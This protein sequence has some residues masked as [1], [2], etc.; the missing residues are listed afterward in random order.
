MKKHYLIGALIAATGIFAATAS[1][2]ERSFKAPEANSEPYSVPITLKPV[3]AEVMQDG[4]DVLDNN[5]DEVKWSVYGSQVRLSYSAPGVTQDDYLFS[6]AVSLET[7]Q[8]YTF[9]INYEMGTPSYTEN[10]SV[11]VANTKDIAEVKQEENLIFSRKDSYASAN[12]VETE[13]FTVESD[14]DYYFAFYCDSPGDHYYVYVN[15]FSVLGKIVPNSVASLKATP[16]SDKSIS[17]SLSW[18]LP[19]TN[20]AGAALGAIEKVVV[21]RDDVQIKELDGSATSYTDTE[22]DG[23]TAGEHTY[24]VMVVVD[25]TESDKAVTSTVYVGP[26]E[27][28]SIPA[29]FEFTSEADFNNWVVIK[30]SSSTNSTTWKYNSVR[31]YAGYDCEYN[32]RNP[33]GDDDWLIA[34]PVKVEEA[35]Y[36]KVVVAGVKEKS[37]ESKLY[38]V[39]GTAPTTEM[40]VVGAAFDLPFDEALTPDFTSDAAKTAFDVY[41]EPGTYYF[42]VHNRLGGN[43]SASNTYKIGG[44]SVETSQAYPGEVTDL[45]AQGASDYSKALEI[46]WT[47]PT[48]DQTG[49]P[50]GDKAFVVKVYVGESETPAKTITDGAASCTI[51]VEAEGSYVVTVVT[52]T[53]EGA[54]SGKK[55]TVASGWV[56]SPFAELPYS[57][58]FDPAKD[59]KLDIWK[60]NIIDGNQDGKTFEIGKNYYG[61]TCLQTQSGAYEYDDYVLSPYLALGAGTYKVAIDWETGGYAD[62]TF[63]AGIIEAG[64]F[65]KATVATA[66]M[67]TTG[68]LAHNEEGTYSDTFVIT[69]EGNYQFVLSHLG[70]NQFAMEYLRVTSFEI[71]EEATY[72][73]DVTDLKVVADSEDDSKAIVSWTNPTTCYESDEALTNI[74]AI[75]VLR[76]GELIA[77]V[78]E[79]ALLVPGAE[80]SFVDELEEGGKYT[81]TVYPTV[82]G[83]GHGG[84]YPTVTSAWIGGGLASLDMDAEDERWSFID[85]HNDF[86]ADSH[87][88]GWCAYAPVATTYLYY[89]HDGAGD[90][91]ADDYLVTPPVRVAEGNIYEVAIEVRPGYNVDSKAYN[92]AVK[93]GVGADSEGWNEVH[94]INI[95]SDAVMTT[96]VTHKFNVAVGSSIAQS[97]KKVEAED[98]EGEEEEEV[99]PAKALYDGAV[100]LAAGSHT[101]AIHATEVGGMCIQNLSFKKVAEYTPVTT[102]LESVST[103]DFDFDGHTATFA[104][105]ADVEIYNLAGVCVHRALQCKGSCVVPPLTPGIY[106]IKVNDRVQKFT[107]K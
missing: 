72:P 60:A 40:T 4:W 66:E 63:V 8:T 69:T 92:A 100:K 64:S 51:P 15:E 97:P 95:A 99:D 93:M 16:A 56:G 103:V 20:T 43:F 11:Y 22:A 80:G 36:F 61:T 13:S 34:P 89:H 68:T 31:N 74:E 1:L 67:V 53:A 41:L 12:T 42:G 98:G 77:T 55:V 9:V 106:F 37:A 18:T 73:G 71:V 75:A 94:T 78:T 2:S 50:W 46:S 62:I 29:T 27:P 49:Q 70:T 30:G 81:Y 28:K 82:N 21:F 84:E 23:L 85:K 6:P 25:G 3:V 88:Y 35:G 65:D 57:T 7:G 48:V 26:L 76:D 38:L 87:K 10:L 52:E 17:C 96:P 19:T 5:N 101:I 104:G 90:N 32:W 105:I 83:R 79:E 86:D 47:N 102:G 24:A 59:S 14:G 45:K 107:A 39:M 44:V 58:T 33:V 54:T 91:E